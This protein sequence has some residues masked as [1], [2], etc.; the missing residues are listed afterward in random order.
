MSSIASNRHQ[1]RK[2]F[3]YQRKARKNQVRFMH[4]LENYLKKY[5]PYQMVHETTEDM[6]GCGKV[7]FYLTRMVMNGEIL[8]ADI[9]MYPD[10]SIPTKGEKA[11][12]GSCGKEIFI[13]QLDAR[14]IRRT[15]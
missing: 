4:Q 15:A 1:R 3:S 10:G 11:K 6:E 14:H 8:D 7:A 13:G 9:A 5:F 12:C 2:E